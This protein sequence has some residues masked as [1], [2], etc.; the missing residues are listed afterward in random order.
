MRDLEKLFLTGCLPN[1]KL[2]GFFLN[3]LLQLDLKSYMQTVRLTLIQINS[4]IQIDTVVITIKSD[5]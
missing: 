4:S 1:S 2:L 3:L 5:H